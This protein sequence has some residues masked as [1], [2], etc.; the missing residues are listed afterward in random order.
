MKVAHDAPAFADALAEAEAL[1]VRTYTR[2]DETLL[3]AAPRL[4]VIGRAGVGLDNVDVPA[5]RARGIEVVY[6]P[7]A[8]T[9]AVVEYVLCLIADAL[10]PRRTVDQALQVRPWE[11][12]RQETSG[13]REMSECTIGILGLGRIG[14]R[15]AQ[16]AGAIGSRVLYNDLVSMPPEAR[17][18]A[19]PVAAENLFE[20][21]DILS[22]HIDGRSDNRDFIGPELITRLKDDVVFLN[23]S[24][25][26][27]VDNVALAGF[28]C[29]HPRAEA[30]LDVHEPEPFDASYPL[31]GLPNA[32]L[33]PHLA[34]RTERAMLNM[35][36][37]VKDVMAVLEGRAPQ[38]PAP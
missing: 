11:Q 28:L 7:E 6:T 20:E 8:N 16:V 19:E 38:W 22:I 30:H 32:K 24:R 10:R 25:G 3:R 26:F 31:L 9:Q 2:V 15:I 13:R 1:L 12:I 21:A 18:G 34:A 35:S 29:A 17:F 27:V 36:W 5:C 4:R 37:V 23:T 33:Y 14:K